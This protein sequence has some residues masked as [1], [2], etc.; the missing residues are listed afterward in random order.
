M[1]GKAD[2]TFP[3]CT[4]AC[5]P[6]RCSPVGTRSTPSLP[7][8]WAGPG[9][10]GKR[11]FIYLISLGMCYCLTGKLHTQTLA[12]PELGRVGKDRSEQWCMLSG[13]SC[14][15]SPFLYVRILTQ[16]L[17]ISKAAQEAPAQRPQP[18]VACKAPAP[19]PRGMS[20]IVS[21]F[22]LLQRLQQSQVPGQLKPHQKVLHS[23]HVS[24]F[25]GLKPQ[26]KVTCMGTQHRH[27]RAGFLCCGQCSP[28]VKDMQQDWQACSLD[29]VKERKLGI[30]P[31]G[32]EPLLG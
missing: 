20:P 8:P 13:R 14:F 18:W 11:F 17:S 6:T 30:S 28:S 4:C 1:G 27:S 23:I 22:L 10:W 32:P 24:H 3:N 9:Q 7:S 31:A 12:G 21:P 5:D 15:P 25:P 16:L 26:G 2:H 19:V 29:S